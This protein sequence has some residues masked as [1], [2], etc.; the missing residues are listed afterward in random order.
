[1]SNSAIKAPTW[2]LVVAGIALVWNLM[3]VMAYI[4]QVTMSPEALAALPAEQQALLAST[5][6]WA[7]GAFALAVFG[8]ALG[9]LALLIRKTWAFPL[10]LISLAAVIVQLFHAFFMSKSI[11]VFGPGGMIMP[12]MVI[13]IAAY[14]LFLAKQAKAKGWLA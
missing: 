2:F 12:L 6:A 11:E 14:L 3:G 13:V 1:M 5:P 9:S 4:A 7:T 10:L 8:G